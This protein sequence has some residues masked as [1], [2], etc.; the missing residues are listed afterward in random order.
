MTT[1]TPPV[2]SRPRPLT[3]AVWTWCLVAALVAQAS[4]VEFEV[5]PAQVT[6]D[7]SFAQVQLLVSSGA[8][9]ATE[10]SAD[11]THAAT[12]VSSDTNIVRVL[13]NNR[14]AAVA[15]GT[16]QVTVTVEGVSKTVPVTVTGVESQPNVDFVEQVLP[17]LSKAGCNAG[18][19]HASQHGKGGFTLSVM[20]YD[21]KADHSAIVRERMQRRVN[22]LSPEDSLLLKKPVLAAPHGGGKRLEKGSPEYAVFAAWIAA[23]CPAP[24][25]DAATVKKLTVTPG[26]RV[27]EI[28]ATQQ[29][30][31]EATY[32]NGRIA[33]VTHWS[34]FDSLD[35][36]VVAVT[37]QGQLT[38]TGKG[39][40]AVMVRFEGQAEISLVSV[41]Y[42]T[43]ADLAAW[44]NNN[45]IDEIAAAKFT[46]LGITPSG[47]C[48]DATFV[49]RAYLDAIG[50]LPTPEETKTFL[51]ASEPDKRA[52]LVNRLLGLT[53][54]PALDTF[55]D[56]Y[57]AYWTIKWSDLLKNRSDTVGDQ[58]MWA[59]H[60]WLRES[61]RVN[62]PFDQFVTE[63]VTAKGPV[64]SNGPAAYFRIANNPLDMAEMTSQLFLG[65]RLGCAK[66]H[67]HPFEKY[68]QADYYSFAAFFPRVGNKVSQEGG[69]FANEIVVTVRMNGEVGHP[70]T[71][72]IMKPTPLEGEPVD[73]PVD[74]RLP[75]AKWLTS[76]EN[77]YFARNLVNRYVR[78]LLGRGLVEPIDDLRATNPPTNPALMQALVN[79]FRTSGFNIKHLMR[80]IMTSRLY[81]LDSQPNATNAADVRFYSHFLVKRLS[82]EPLLDSIDMACGTQT[83]FPNLPLG[84]RAIELPDAEYQ[85]YFLQTFGK[86]KRVSV[87]ECERNPDEN[88]AQALHVLN[89]DIVQG[90][91]VDANGRIA[92]LLKEQKPHE[93][94]VTELYLATLSRKPSQAE[95]DATKQFLA[96]SPTPA[97]CY[98]DLLWALFN[99]KQFLFVN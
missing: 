71:G 65:V 28:G 1:G 24:K 69:L 33:D 78:Y 2:I 32:S 31:V 96:D 99:T 23:G 17:V 73:D 67:H 50:T 92:K 70:K 26:R 30:R 45:F 42:G 60:N 61:F 9:T 66:C 84:T 76:K 59:L 8:G 52:K 16:A 53:G 43:T 19:C 68:S 56:K 3:V 10:Q 95:L 85:N 11:L 21:P 44:T 7:N 14:L 75:L 64:F 41:P 79:D 5:L 39:Q 46:E 38:I 80:S 48:D 77:D 57:A 18:A 62:K 4:A 55:N 97:E 37:P 35:E 93:E 94:I 51:E 25:A 83:K 6:L 89:G 12:L 22:L 13:P 90:K 20:G 34:R 15:N 82:A 36:A 27:A 86:P 29:L 47:L 87:C 54:D 63:L 40:A 91:I 98:Q 81:Q 58:G 49:R 74:R 72:Q 88:L